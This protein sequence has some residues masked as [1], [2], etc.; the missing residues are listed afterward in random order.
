V[1]VRGLHSRRW[2]FLRAVERFWVT[3]SRPRITRWTPRGSVMI[4]S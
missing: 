4:G 1:F 3:L 2:R